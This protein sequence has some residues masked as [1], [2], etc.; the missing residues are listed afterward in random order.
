MENK[1]ENNQRNIRVNISVTKEVYDYFKEKS[2][3]TYISASALYF[4]VLEE[5][6]KK[7]TRD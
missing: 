3:K 1:Q 6:V 7:M 5:H 4:L 2:E